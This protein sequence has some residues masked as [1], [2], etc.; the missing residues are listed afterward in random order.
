MTGRE[1]TDMEDP[2]TE[3]KGADIEG[4]VT[5]RKKTGMEGRVTEVGYQHGG[6][7]NRKG[8]YRHLRP[9]DR[10]RVIL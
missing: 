8:R 7:H 2:V 1:G 4:P 10:L 3:R 6:L 9:R 5:E